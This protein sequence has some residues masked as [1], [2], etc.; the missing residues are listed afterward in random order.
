LVVVQARK[1]DVVL[2]GG[3]IGSLLCVRVFSNVKEIMEE[4]A[5]FVTEDPGLPR[6]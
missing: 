1:A 3:G 6:W 2:L 5:N 4:N